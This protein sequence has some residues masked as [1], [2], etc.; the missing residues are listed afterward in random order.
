L[1]EEALYV[2]GG[3]MA[4]HEVASHLGGMTRVNIRRHA[5]ALLDRCQLVDVLD[6]DPK[7]GALHVFHPSAAATTRGILVDDDGWQ[8]SR[9][10]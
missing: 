2:L 1:S 6:A 9:R 5:N 7:S 8:R 3:H 4:L 10:S